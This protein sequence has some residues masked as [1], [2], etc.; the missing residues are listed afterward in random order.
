[1]AVCFSRPMFA[2]FSCSAAMQYL[3]SPQLNI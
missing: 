2:A 3:H 1:M